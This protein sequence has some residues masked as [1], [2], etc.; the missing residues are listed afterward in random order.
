MTP[1]V[2]SLIPPPRSYLCML[3]PHFTHFIPLYSHLSPLL[4]PSLLTLSS[5]LSSS[6]YPLLPPPPLTLPSLPSSSSYP[7]LPLLLLSS[8]SL[9]PSGL[10][11]IALIAIAGVFSYFRSSSMMMMM[12]CDRYCQCTRKMCNPHRH[13]HASTRYD[14]HLSPSLSLNVGPGSSPN[15]SAH[16]SSNRLLA[17]T[18]TSS[19]PT[20][21]SPSSS[22]ISHIGSI[23]WMLLWGW[24]WGSVCRGCGLGSGRPGGRWP[25]MMAIQRMDQS[26]Q[27]PGLGLETRAKD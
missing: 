21:T 13:A 6:S 24:G 10:L 11:L 17:P 2:A 7:L 15:S 22:L 27:V 4:L 16:H 18:P 1:L 25:S 14:T 3:F 23:L 8:L 19:T 12:P 5:L 9:L 26:A 20:P